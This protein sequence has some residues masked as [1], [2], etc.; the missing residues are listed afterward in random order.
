[1]RFKK[2]HFGICEEIVGK[3]IFFLIR[4]RLVLV[5]CH[6]KLK[7]LNYI[8]KGFSL[9]MLLYDVWHTEN[10]ILNNLWR[11]PNET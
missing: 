1:M 8:E 9:L 3:K 2:E 7:W 6:K 11:K 10:A 4:F 5:V